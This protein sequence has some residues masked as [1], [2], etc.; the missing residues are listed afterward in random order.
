MADRQERWQTGHMAETMVISRRSVIHPHNLPALLESKDDERERKGKRGK[1][2][3]AK[4]RERESDGET[5]VHK[6]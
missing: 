2:Q 3:R 4:K 6:C 5:K 1:S